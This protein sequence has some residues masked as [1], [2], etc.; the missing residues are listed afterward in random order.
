MRLFAHADVRLI[1]LGELIGEDSCFGVEEYGK[2]FKNIST[3][4][5]ISITMI[6]LHKYNK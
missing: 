4:E 1:V 2:K 6:I 5:L 3:T